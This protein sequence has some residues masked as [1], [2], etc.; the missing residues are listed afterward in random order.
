MFK[1]TEAT[2]GKEQ[3]GGTVVE[4]VFFKLRDTRTSQ[5]KN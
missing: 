1:Q 4:G 2:R 5:Q 3:G